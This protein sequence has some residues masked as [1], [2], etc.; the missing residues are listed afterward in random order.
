MFTNLLRSFSHIPLVNRSL[1]FY[2]W[3]FF[4]GWGMFAPIL[5]VFIVREL[6][7]SVTAAGMA[8]ALPWLTRAVFQIPISMILDRTE[9]EWDDLLALAFNP[10]LT[11]ATMIGL[12]FANQ[13]FLV[14][15]FQFFGGI[16]GALY[17]AAW[18]AIFSRHL[19]QGHVSLQWSLDSATVAVIIGLAGAI[20]GYLAD[21]FGF[22]IL[23]LVVA[24]FSFL[25]LIPLLKARKLVQATSL[26][27]KT[28]SE[29]KG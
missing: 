15:I 21:N 17:G 26:D 4:L 9:S 1:M 14:Y 25:A 13:L 27:K 28:S 12:Y 29:E 8:L 5:S 19:D 10:I 7:G 24:G 11:G 23:F 6:G 2:D 16:A 20:G 22:R 3:T 18:P